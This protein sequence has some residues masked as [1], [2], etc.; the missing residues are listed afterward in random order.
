MQKSK[1][2]LLSAG[3]IESVFRSRAL[4]TV[5][6][7]DEK[8]TKYTFSWPEYERWLER[9]CKLEYTEVQT[10]PRGI[11]TERVHRMSWGSYF[12]SEQYNEDIAEYITTFKLRP[13]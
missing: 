6:L 8:E 9:E 10:S 13:L 3:D 7:N 11:V 4:V 12:E 2:N 1:K 5:H